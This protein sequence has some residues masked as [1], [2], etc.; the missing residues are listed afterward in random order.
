M[1]TKKENEIIKTIYNNPKR[2]AFKIS[3]L[4]NTTYAYTHKVIKTFLKKGIVISTRNTDK[5]GKAIVLSKLGGVI[6][7]S[8]FV[9]EQNLNKTK[10]KSIKTKTIK[11]TTKKSRSG[12][13]ETRR[14]KK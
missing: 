11:K 3:V 9:Y 1:L 8:I 2:T 13:H 12:K 10:T 4:S 6:A 5:R 7:E 14:N